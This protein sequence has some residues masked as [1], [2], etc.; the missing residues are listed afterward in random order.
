MRQSTIT[1]N[2]S[3]EDYFELKTGGL[4]PKYQYIDTSVIELPDDLPQPPSDHGVIFSGCHKLINIDTLAKWDTSNMT[5]TSGMFNHCRSLVDISPLR[6]WN[7]SNVIDM[8]CMFN[9]CYELADVSAIKIWDISNAKRMRFIFNGC[10][11]LPDFARFEVCD[12]QT[13]NCFVDRYLWS[14]PTQYPSYH[15]QSDESNESL[16]ESEMEEEEECYEP[17][18]ETTINQHP[19]SRTGDS[20]T[21]TVLPGT[22]YKNTY[23]DPCQVE[24]LSDSSSDDISTTLTPEMAR[25][26][27]EFNED[28]DY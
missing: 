24:D 4:G 10:H 5:S 6:Y 26:C 23:S 14:P 7:L 19:F 28:D 21:A 11:K 22:I 8:T 1:Q 9:C 25:R 18:D 16:L 12:Q 15:N 2:P 13:F 3:W 27:L 20:L 17:W